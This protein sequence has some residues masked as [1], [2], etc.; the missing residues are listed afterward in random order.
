MK[1]KFHPGIVAT[2]SAVLILAL[3]SINPVSAQSDSSELTA[4]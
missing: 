4:R 2:F 3:A 1:V